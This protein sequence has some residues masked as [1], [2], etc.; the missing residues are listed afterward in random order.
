MENETL[1]GNVGR[2]LPWVWI[3]LTIIVDYEARN[4]LQPPLL[5]GHPS[6]M[7]KWSFNTYLQ[8]DNLVAFDISVLFHYLGTSETWHKRGGIW[9]EGDFWARSHEEGVKLAKEG[10][11]HT[12]EYIEDKRIDFHN[13]TFQTYELA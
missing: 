6:A 7:K 9:L 3:K 8:G 4:T 10:I 5:L 12:Q 2:Y 11:W 1:R 13:C